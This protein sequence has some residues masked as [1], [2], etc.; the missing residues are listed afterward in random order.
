MNHQRANVVVLLAMLWVMNHAPAQQP[1]PPPPAEPAAPVELSAQRFTE[2]AYGISIQAPLNARVQTHVGGDLLM[3]VRDVGEEYVITL[4]A[5]QAVENR[6]LS[7]E[8]VL[9]SMKQAMFKDQ[10][11]MRVIEERKQAI[12]ER[13]SAVVYFAVPQARRTDSVAMIG[14]AIIP[15]DPVRFALIQVKC[16]ILAEPRVRPL[17]DTI[18]G[19]VRIDDPKKLAAERREAIERSIQWRAEHDAKHRH[20]ALVPMQHLLFEDDGK[21][22]GFV[23]ISQF[24]TNRANVPGVQVEIHTRIDAPKGGVVDSLSLFFIA[25]DDSQEFW[26]T[27]TTHRL[28]GEIERPDKRG[29]PPVPKNTFV[30]SGLRVGKE[31]QVSYTGP[32]GTAS[33]S[34]PIPPG[35][36]SLAEVYL[37]PQTLPRDRSG[38]WGFYWYNPNEKKVTFRTEQITPTLRGYTVTTL[39]DPNA[40]PTRATYDRDGTLIE[41]EVGPKRKLAKTTPAMIEQLMRRR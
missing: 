23:K 38:L 30:E 16:P 21:H 11:S 32:D 4:Q 36:I 7:A 39:S 26:K 22:I 6:L 20:A 27:T 33:R 37:L 24:Q 10:P 5:V 9:A 2:Q 40:P 12:A 14:Q 35:Y 1:A 25:D 31:I 18:L 41:R 17:F 13:E 28:P 15:L 29:N 19:T 8:Q 3:T 34:Y